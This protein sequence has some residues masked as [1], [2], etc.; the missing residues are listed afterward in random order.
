[1]IELGNYN[2]LKILRSTSVGL[3]LGDDEGTEILLPN[4]YVP[5]DVRPD[6]MLSVFC[7][8]DHQERPIA[9]TLKPKI[10]RNGFAYL[11]VVEVN[12]IGAFL[13]WGLEK[14][15]F[16]PFR[17]QHSRLTAGHRYVVHCYLDE[18]SF[19]LVG[20]TKLDKFLKNTEHD[21]TVNDEVEIL[22]SRKTE[23]GWE[24]IIENKY[25]G[26]IFF[27][28]VFKPLSIGLSLTGYVKNVRDDR[29]VDIVLQ[30]IGMKMLDEVANTIYEKLKAADGFIPL[31]DKSPP[32]LIKDYLQ[33]SKK[34]FKKG[35]GVL[36]K[37]RKILI[38]EDG[39]QLVEK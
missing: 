22:V 17:E 33:M 34:A 1:M 18:Q 32:E 35:V 31:N 4:K 5:E 39:I 3:F 16:V 9:T 7:Y 27:S 14:H 20:S 10:I 12:E 6:D 29:K 37:N 21:F 24:V 38:K 15:L 19:R 25:K 8:L 26:L 13:D 30:P 11:E 28:D 36:Y 2:E 23:L